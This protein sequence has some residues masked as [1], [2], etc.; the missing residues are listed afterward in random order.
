LFCFDFVS[1]KLIRY[2]VILYIA[3]TCFAT[4]NRYVI[5]IVIDDKPIII[6]EN[7]CI[8]YKEKYFCLSRNNSKDTSVLRNRD[9]FNGRNTSRKIGID[10]NISK[11]NTNKPMTTEND[12][13]K[14]CVMFKINNAKEISDLWFSYL[15]W[16]MW[17]DNLHKCIL[18]IFLLHYC[19]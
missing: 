17:R 10:S 18:P 7:S 13:K 12:K 15:I 3:Q 14:T 9:S 8:I 2:P 19:S 4:I 6:P 16:I 1:L 11:K 5:V